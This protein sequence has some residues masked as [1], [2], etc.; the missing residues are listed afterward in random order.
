[1]KIATGIATEMHQQ[2]GVGQSNTMAADD[3]R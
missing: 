1:L 2:H 3:R